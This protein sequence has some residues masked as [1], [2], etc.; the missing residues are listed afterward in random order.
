M[1]A[2]SDA[3]NDSS[4]DGP[5]LQG[6]IYN[7]VSRKHFA[8]AATGWGGLFRFEASVQV[9]SIGPRTTKV[10]YSLGAEGFMGPIL[11]MCYAENIRLSVELGLE[12]L[13][14]LAQETELT[15]KALD[16]LT[17]GVFSSL[18]EIL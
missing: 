15:H 9:Q 8:V 5:A 3:E 16:D 7:F 4:L 2:S 11:S 13:S 14:Q 1:C 12:A 18:S 6:E 17:F 10:T